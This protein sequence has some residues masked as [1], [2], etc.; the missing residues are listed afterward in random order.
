MVPLLLLPLPP[1]LLAACA[2]ASSSR[3]SLNTCA[4][5]RSLARPLA[6]SLARSKVGVHSLRASPLT[7]N[8][9]RLKYGTIVRPERNAVEKREIKIHILELTLLF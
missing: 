9:D 2:S 4:T 7:R 8:S 1:R 6:R 5:A 3:V